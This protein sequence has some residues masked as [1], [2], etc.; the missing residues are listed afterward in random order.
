MFGHFDLTGLI[1]KPRAVAEESSCSPDA[2]R[3][4]TGGDAISRSQGLG[5]DRRVSGSSPISSNSLE[6]A[7]TSTTART[8][9]LFDDLSSPHCELTSC[10]ASHPPHPRL[11]HDRDMRAQRHP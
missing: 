2:K 4:R 5:A 8:G 7:L 3:G 10:T 1:A 11:T 6:K 9:H